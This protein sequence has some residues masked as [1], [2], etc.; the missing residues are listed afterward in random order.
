MNKPQTFIFVGRSGSGK[1]TQIELLQKYI[2]EQM[3]EIGSYLFVMG[4]HS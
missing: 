2:K 3:P 4:E 1:G